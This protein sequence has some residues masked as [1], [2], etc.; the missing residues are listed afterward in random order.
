MARSKAQ[1]RGFESLP[2]RHSRSR[3]ISIRGVNQRVLGDAESLSSGRIRTY[4]P[5]VNSRMLLGAELTIARIPLW[6]EV[7]RD[8]NAKAE[9]TFAVRPVSPERYRV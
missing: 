9:D 5:P 3:R 6:P 7:P 1:G 2:L 8:F 4:N